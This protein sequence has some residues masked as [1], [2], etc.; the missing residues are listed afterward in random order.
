MGPKARLE[1]RI[2]VHINIFLLVNILQ[3][4][5]E[6]KLFR[7]LNSIERSYLFIIKDVYYVIWDFRG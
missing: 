2:S 7:L 6:Q 1:S 5:I 4:H 3:R